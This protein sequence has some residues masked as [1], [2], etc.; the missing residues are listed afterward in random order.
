MIIKKITLLLLFLFLVFCPPFFLRSEVEAD[1]AEILTLNP[2]AD[3]YVRGVP[4]ADTNYGTDESLKTKVS[5]AEFTRESF[6]RFDLSSVTF[7]VAHASLRLYPTG[8][9]GTDAVALVSDN[10]W[11]E[12]T[13]TWNNKPDSGEEITTWGAVVGEYTEI[14]LTAQ[15]QTALLGD[16]KISVHIY[17]KTDDVN[18]NYGARESA[19]PPELLVTDNQ[20]PEAVFS[21]DPTQGD[22]APLL[23]DF[24]AGLSSD[25]DGTVSGYGWDF[26]DDQSGSGVTTSHAY[27]TAG[28][29]TITLTVTDNQGSTDTA[30]TTLVVGSQIGKS[31]DALNFYGY[32]DDTNPDDQTFVIT[33][34]K[35]GT[36]N[37]TISDDANW[38]SLSPTSGTTTT[39]EDEITA[40]VDIT[41][42]SE[43]TY[44]GTVTITD[45]DAANNPQT[46]DIALK[47]IFPAFP[48][49]EGFGA[50]SLGGRDGQV[51]EVTNLN[52]SGE[53]SLRACVQ[54][55]GPRTCVFKVAGTITLDTTLK[56]ENSNITVAGQAAPGG[57][58][59]L[60]NNP[61]TNGGTTIWVFADDVII[62]YLRIRSGASIENSC[63]INAIT[64]TK[65]RNI[66]IDHVSSSWTVDQTMST[67]NEYPD[68]NDLENVTIQWSF[69][70][71][72]LN[73][74][75]HTKG[76]HSTAVI[77]GAADTN[78]IS[79]HHNLMAHHNARTP[80]VK[81][82]GPVDVVNNV[83]YNYGQEL[84]YSNT[85]Y[86]SFS[87]N[88]VGNYV[89][90]GPNLA[91]SDPF[92]KLGVG[93]GLTLDT[94]VQGNIDRYRTSDDLPEY[95][96][97]KNNGSRSYLVDE[98]NSAPAIT[99]TLATEAYDQVL[100][101]AGATYGLD[102]QGNYFLRRDAVDKRNIEEVERGEGRI[103]DATSLSTMYNPEATI[104]LTEED[105]TQYGITDPIAED[106]WPILEEGTAYTDSDHDGMAD[107]WETIYFAG[108]SR[109]SA[110]DSSGDYDS[111][112]YTD[113]EEFLNGTDPTDN[114]PTSTP[115][116][117]PPPT[118]TPTPTPTATP[119]STPISAVVP[120]ATSASQC[121]SL[122][123]AK[124]PI[125]YAA[126]S[127]S[128][129]TVIISFYYPPDN[130][131]ERTGY[132]L[133]YG[134]ND[135]PDHYSVEIKNKDSQNFTIDYLKPNI[136]YCFK[137][138]A[139]NSCVAGPF[140]LPFCLRTKPSVAN[141][142]NLTNLEAE[143]TKI[144]TSPPAETTRDKGQQELLAP[145]YLNIIPDTVSLTIR[146]LDKQNKPVKG[147]TVEIYSDVQIA[148][149]NDSGIAVFNNVDKGEHTLK[150]A[151][152]GYQGEQ[153]L[154]L[155]DETI[156]QYQITVRIERKESYLTYG[157]TAV[158]VT[159]L[160]VII[161]ILK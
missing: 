63:C 70:N 6:I 19:T 30:Q 150:V 73:K 89:K 96:C 11:G 139:L 71:E 68:I 18:N 156:S 42:L 51:I 78:N 124:P 50:A 129:N 91:T 142:S 67:W 14:D 41:G 72:S 101:Q 105:Y 93:T 74:S 35:L 80:R 31:K 76:A 146:V 77:F 119:T 138:A 3:A 102:D 86:G 114:L 44:T 87:L 33:N 52:D 26:G 29:Y 115:T 113:L 132:L 13:I 28:T 55:T 98:R 37:W 90:V 79:F 25:P 8:I 10:A 57:G 34:S 117:T 131:S 88:F 141:L 97:V 120:A 147:A 103:I 59:T 36:L 133:N 125:L 4:Y 27:T 148:K 48:G 106:G 130:P 151:Y 23:V 43:G 53:G 109:G 104:Y 2:E 46:I 108:L 40:S 95:L 154:N 136:N 135:S 144:E 84:S 158:I 127:N 62:R 39:E 121:T 128:P 140:S 69:I 92:I 61:A 9:G 66:I 155:A 160:G 17:A 7:G 118:P 65:G 112:G 157:L 153:V 20:P 83:V 54:E 94:Y 159:L 134:E 24:D 21:I 149:T 107:E 110:D 5:D 16:K 47:V 1:E 81:V 22:V 100:D 45:P 38:L 32:K 82:T 49:A 56:I 85:A 60:R 64:I 58:I 161:F 143:I 99:T 137:L 123:P 75:T 111:D 126:F 152:R 116:P 145:D 122:S 15:V 12:S